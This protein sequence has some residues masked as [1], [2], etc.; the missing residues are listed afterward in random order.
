MH[1]QL[2]RGDAPRWR[3]VVVKFCA[4]RLEVQAEQFGNEITQHLGVTAP[5]SRILR[6]SGLL[7]GSAMWH[8]A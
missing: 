2:W 1:S 6:V 8:R 3:C 5:R 4:T 7:R